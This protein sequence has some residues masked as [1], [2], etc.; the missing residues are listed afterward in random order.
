M[1]RNTYVYKEKEFHSIKDLA[2]FVGKNEKTITA[3]L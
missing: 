3:R 1:V 2:K